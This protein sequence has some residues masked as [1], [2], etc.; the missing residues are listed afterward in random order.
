MSG[1]LHKSKGTTNTPINHDSG[2]MPSGDGDADFEGDA[3]TEDS[4]DDIDLF[5]EKQYEK[6]KSKN[7]TKHKNGRPGRDIHPILF[8]GLSEFSGLIYQTTR[9]RE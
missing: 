3:D 6:T 5:E 4:D 1:K 9:S 7:W 8:T 2:I